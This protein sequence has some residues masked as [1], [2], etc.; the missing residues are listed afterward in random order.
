[1]PVPSPTRPP[2]S[3]VAASIHDEEESTDA[4]RGRRA[5][6]GRGQAPGGRLTPLRSRPRPRRRTIAGL[7]TCL[8]VG[9]IVLLVVSLSPQAWRLSPGTGSAPSVGST[10]NLPASAGTTLV[11]QTSVGLVPTALDA[12]WA[13]YSDHSTC[14]NWAGGDGISA[15]RL[16]PSQIAWFFSDSYLGPAGP[17]AGFSQSTGLI[18]NSVVIQTLSGQGSGFVTLTGGGVCS[19]TQRP[20]AVV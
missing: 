8:S 14:A 12:E 3:L 1:M 20:A 17:S 19:S 9:L 15:V 5:G 4:R 13:G 2:R 10:G 16:S 7:L 11:P 18:H 6:V